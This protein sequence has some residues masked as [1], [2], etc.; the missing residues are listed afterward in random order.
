MGINANNT[1]IISPTKSMRWET[2][3]NHKQIDE[4][5]SIIRTRHFQFDYSI[6]FRYIAL[7]CRLFSSFFIHVWSFL[8]SCLVWFLGSK[9]TNNDIRKF[10]FILVWR[11]VRTP[12]KNLSNNKSKK[13]IKNQSDEKKNLPIFKRTSKQVFILW[14]L[15]WFFYIFRLWTISYF[16]CSFSSFSWVMS[17][18]AI[19]LALNKFSTSNPVW[20]INTWN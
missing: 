15:C 16:F 17:M 5:H 10:S 14:S 4:N 2:S 3:Q 13:S 11:C 12:R 9:Q 1:Q 20:W 8:S 18:Y 19:L 7:M 6:H